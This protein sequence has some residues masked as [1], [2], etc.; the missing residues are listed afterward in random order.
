VNATPPDNTSRRSSV[1]NVVDL[2]KRALTD[3][4]GPSTNMSGN[5]TRVD[6]CSD[7]HCGLGWNPFVSK[8]TGEVD[9]K[10]P[11]T[12]IRDVVTNAPFS[13]V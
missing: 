1:S 6:I 9:F 3:K 5:P 4:V 12:Q 13:Q 2:G 11:I 7:G 10:F 8:D